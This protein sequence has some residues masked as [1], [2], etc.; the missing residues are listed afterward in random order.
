MRDPAL[1]A[2][3]ASFSIDEGSPALRF[4]A[5]L[6]RENRWTEDHA[7]RVVVEYLRFVYLAAVSRETLTPSVAVDQAWH[8][9]LCYTRS[10]WHALCR[11][12]LGRELH[13]GPTR[14]GHAEN[15]RYHDCYERTLRLYAEEFGTPPPA[16]LWPAAA[17][18]FA[19]DA[20]PV[21]V[22]PADYLLVSKPGLKR[23]AL[24]ASTVALAG[25]ALGALAQSNHGL[26]WVGG[27]FLFIALIITINTLA[28]RRRR[29]P[30]RRD[31]GPGGCGSA[32]CGH[33]T[34]DNGGSDGDSGCGSGCGGGCGGGD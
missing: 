28:E 13:H 2:R 3:L 14:G 23:L 27:F 34:S 25:L 15:T 8:L 18:R 20:I 10:Y 1:A 11:E 30:R 12:I 7:R 24:A 9:H 16:D 22:A 31:P 5:R 26:A 33:G 19:S 29:G 32:G 17:H 21:A 4:A 6:A